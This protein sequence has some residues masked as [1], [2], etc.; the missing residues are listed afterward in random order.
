M[1]SRIVFVLLLMVG[2]MEAMAQI[3]DGK[4]KFLGNITPSWASI[5]S[6]FNLY[7]NQVTPENAGKWGS[8]EGSRDNMQWTYL[9]QAYNHAKNNGFLFR[10]HTLVWG[11]QQPNWIDGDPQATQREEVEEWIRLFGE[12]YPETN[13]IDVVNEP[14]H[15][16]PVYSTALGGSGKTG[17]DWVV[18]SFKKARQYCP[19]AQLHINDYGIIGSTSAT[20]QYLQII[21]ILLDSNLIDGIGVQAHGLESADTAILRANLDRLAETGLPIYITEYDVNISDDQQQYQTYYKQFPIFWKHPSV[22]GV[23]LWGY[24][25]GHIWKADA[26]LVRSDGSERPALTWLRTY[27]TTTEIT[28]FWTAIEEILPE[29]PGG[30]RM[31]PNPVAGGMLTIQPEEGMTQARLLDM[32][33]RLIREILLEGESRLSIQLD[34]PAGMYLVQFRKGSS[35]IVEKLMVR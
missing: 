14:L 13:F 4:C 30:V 31:Y 12:R 3:A 23:T 10:M 11:N 29:F 5:P 8:V 2:G 25:Q 7:W 34:V 20:T 28:C 33:G 6:N 26:Y 18:W 19:S 22:A 9:D 15:A 21:E 24:N 16:P 35:V 17:W 32:N 1:I 27:V